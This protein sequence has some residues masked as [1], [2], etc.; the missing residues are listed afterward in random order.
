[1][2]HIYAETR[3]T[4]LKLIGVVLLMVLAGSVALWAADLPIPKRPTEKGS[5]IAWGTMFFDSGQ[6][7]SN[8]FVAIAA[9]GVHSLALRKNGSIVGWGHN[10]YG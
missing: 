8:D 2:G 6:L 5:V 10:D 9:G 1:M 4:N 3:M 7:A